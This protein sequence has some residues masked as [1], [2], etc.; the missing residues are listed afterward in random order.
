MMWKLKEDSTNP[1]ITAEKH[2]K[3]CHK[4]E[5]VKLPKTAIV[6][7]MGRGVDYLKKH[8]K[9]R[10]ITEHLPSFLYFRPVYKLKNQDICFLHGGWGAPMAADTIETLAVLGVENII[11]VGMLGGLTTI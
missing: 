9:C 10:L 11:S 3:S 5:A 8:Q 7:Y 6:F 4:G 1:V 2:I